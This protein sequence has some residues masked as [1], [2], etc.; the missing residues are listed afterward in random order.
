MTDT[1]TQGHNDG[2][3]RL[4]VFSAPSGAGKTTLLDYLR[5]RIPGLGYSISATTRSPR[6]G[7]RDGVH[8]HFM[9]AE[10]F[11]E[12]IECDELAEW[13]QV[14]GN[15]YGTP[16]EPVDRALAAGRHVVMDIDVYG[17]RKLDRWYPD[18][19]GI[20]I[21]PP[22]WEVLERRLRARGT[23]SEETIQ[24]RLKNAR[25]EVR[26]AKEEGKYEYTVVNDDLEATKRELLRL[27]RRLIG[28]ADD[29]EHGG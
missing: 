4:L 5:E 27:V 18:A 11:R 10:A 26:V 16:R 28:L 25:E 13:Q 2:R 12:L 8:Y 23:D 9:S 15:F 19:I 20:L 24:L 1:D 7:E 29:D 22:S 14:H 17:K 21:V 6:P 3:G